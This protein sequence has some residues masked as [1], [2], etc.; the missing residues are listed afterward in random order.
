MLDEFPL[1]ERLTGTTIATYR[2]EQLVSRSP[3]GA[4]YVAQRG[5]DNGAF[6]LRIIALP[7]GEAGARPGASRAATR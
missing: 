7:R 1:L 2:L 3:L 6:L 5:S 4:V